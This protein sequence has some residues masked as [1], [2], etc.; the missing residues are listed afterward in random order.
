M[1]G[2]KLAKELRVPE[3]QGSISFVRKNREVSY[4]NVPR[5]LPSGT[6]DP[7]RFIGIEVSFTPEMDDFFGIRNVKRGV[8]PHGLLRD[9]IRGHL[10]RHIP[11]ARK[12]ID[13]IWGAVSREDQETTGE[14][15]PIPEAVK[16]V[17]ATMPKPRAESDLTAE[18][19]D[20]ALKELAKDVGKTDEKEQ[21]KYIEKIKSLPYFI[22]SVDFPGNMFISTQ[23]LAGKVVIRL[24]TRHPFYREMWEP[25]KQIAER[26]AG[27]VSGEE[28]VKTAR[29]TIEA[30][31]LLLISYGKAESM[32]P[33][34]TDQ[35][36]DLTQFWGQFLA[37]MLH[38]V[39]NVL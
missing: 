6:Q 4:T 34:P 23:H 24:N 38:K 2:D 12:M 28:A 15:T 16:D 10:A 20:E 37:T 3:N 39:K 17:D 32:H 33:T 26:D 21:E 35:Y 22:E 30:L 25:I 11:L 36:A 27:T 19:V 14:H 8:E 13:E 1:G 5:I 29:R 7:D 18:Q 31:T 9:Q